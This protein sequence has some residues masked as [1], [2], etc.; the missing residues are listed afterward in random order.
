MIVIFSWSC[1]NWYGVEVNMEKIKTD[2]LFIGAGPGGYAGAIYAKKK[3]LDVVLVDREWIGGTCLNVGCIPTKA[4]VRSSETFHALQTES[5]GIHAD[6]LSIDLSQVIDQKDKVKNALVSGIEYLLKKHKIN[7][8]QGQAQFI[9]DHTVR[10]GQTEI[11][12]KDI[13]IAS[14]SKS[15]HL[16]IEGKD[17]FIDSRA[18]L[19]NRDLPK[20]MTVIG[21]GI[22]GM[23][24]AFI[25]QQMGVDVHVIEFLP[26]ILPGIDKELA[27]RLMPHAKKSGMKII[28]NAKVIKAAL[29]DGQ[30][31]VYYE[32]NG[33]E[34]YVDSDLV[35]E[36]I[37]RGPVVEGLGLEHTKINYDQR[38]GIAVNDYM[39]TNLEHVYAIGDVNNLMQ[40]AHVA[41]HQALIAVD[42][43]LGQAQA[44]NL[45]HVPSVIFTNPTIA[46]VGITE[47]MAKDRNI[48]IETVKAPFSANGKALILEADRGYMKLIR[49]QETQKLIGAMVIGKEAENLIATLGLAIQ[50]GMEAKDVYHTIFAHPTVQE[51]VHES[52]LGLDKLAIHFME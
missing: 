32:R 15:K 2:V 16:P 6:N 23:E 50:K 42:H 38:N 41:T 1:Y 52:A 10:V 9:D 8:I 27:M 4:L 44:F 39:Q 37:G 35:L 11:V 5:F 26:R 29:V 33:Q 20:T 45:D 25:Y 43:I 19:D 34:H 17:L 47:A 46:T 12:A 36:A 30:K 22:I 48:P 24:F 51:L 7:Y 21:G 14:G 49:H 3:G 28:T 18:L 31:R 13:V 40:L